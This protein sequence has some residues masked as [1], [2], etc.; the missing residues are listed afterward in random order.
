[1]AA[2][3]AASSLPVRLPGMV[4]TPAASASRLADALSPSRSMV[5]AVGPMKTSPACSTARAKAAF[6]ARKPKP[7]WIASAP[8]CCAAAITA[9]IRR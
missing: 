9:S 3:S 6:S 5:S 2:I 7:G 4:G 8:L 1:M